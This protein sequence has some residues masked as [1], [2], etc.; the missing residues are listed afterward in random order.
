MADKQ[1]KR[2]EGTPTGGTAAG[3]G[4]QTGQP[5]DS[6]GSRDLVPGEHTSGAR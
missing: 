6:D 4:S 2:T 5:A 3:W 1:P